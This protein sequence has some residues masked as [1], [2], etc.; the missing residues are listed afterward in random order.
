M[1]DLAIEI[2]ISPNDRQ[3][4]PRRSG[5]AT[6]PKKPKVSV[7]IYMDRQCVAN[8]SEP[9]SA[10]PTPD[11]ESPAM[12]TNPWGLDREYASSADRR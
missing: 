12:P 9:A 1:A 8:T 11:C 6:L 7:R 3:R 4:S 5:L 2:Y 10:G